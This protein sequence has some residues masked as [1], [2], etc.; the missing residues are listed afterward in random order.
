MPQQIECDHRFAA[1]GSTYYQNAAMGFDRFGIE[2]LE[3]EACHHSASRHE[4]VVP[5]TWVQ[6]ERSDSSSDSGGRCFPSAT[7]RRVFT[8]SHP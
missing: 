7:S 6:S 2:F 3:P 5:H 4:K 8:E 1:A